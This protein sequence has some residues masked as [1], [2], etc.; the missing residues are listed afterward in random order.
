M[1]NWTEMRT[2]ALTLLAD[3]KWHDTEELVIGLQGF[4]PAKCAVDRY[5]SWFKIDRPLEVKVAMGRRV[6]VMDRL[7][8]WKHR[9]LIEADGK[10]GVN[11]SYRLNNKE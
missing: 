8:G 3:G 7:N 6:L 1:T 5:T 4:I 2:A 11:R 10:P 9:G